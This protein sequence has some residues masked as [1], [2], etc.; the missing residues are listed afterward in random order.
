MLLANRSGWIALSTNNRTS[1]AIS[2]MPPRSKEITT[3]RSPHPD[4]P[5]PPDREAA[6]GG[7]EGGGGGYSV[8]LPPQDGTGNPSHSSPFPPP[9]SCGYDAGMGDK[10]KKAG[11][12]P[13]IVALLIGLPVLYVA[14]SGP[15]YRLASREHVSFDSVNSVYEP[16]DWIVI[17]CPDAV[18]GAWIDWFLFWAE[19]APD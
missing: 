14:S 7:S 4:P 17:R 9:P 5:R 19:L 16:V 11:V 15:A 2:D 10:R 12:W 18:Q 6:G 3:R 8:S 1:V 13:W